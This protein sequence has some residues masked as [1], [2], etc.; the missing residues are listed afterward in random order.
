MKYARHILNVLLQTKRVT[1]DRATAIEVNGIGTVV[2]IQLIP[3]DV[4]V[5]VAVGK[6]SLI[7]CGELCKCLFNIKLYDC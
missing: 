7:V 6:L 2:T 1:G 5:R 3:K 4:N